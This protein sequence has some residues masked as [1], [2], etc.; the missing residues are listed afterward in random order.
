M[1]RRK[2]ND[3]PW[4][5]SPIFWGFPTVGSIKLGNEGGLFSTHLQNVMPETKIE[6]EEITIPIDVQPGTI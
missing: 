6:I 3:Q 1:L 4:P 2:F 5:K